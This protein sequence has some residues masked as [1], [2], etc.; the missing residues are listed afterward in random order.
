MVF[1]SGLLANK[2][3]RA[4]IVVIVALGLFGLAWQDRRARI[5]EAK[6]VT[7]KYSLLKVAYA[8]QDTENKNLRTALKRSKTREF[9]TERRL[10]SGEVIITTSRFEETEE[11][12]TA[13]SESTAR[14]VLPSSELLA[15]G[16]VTAPLAFS[17]VATVDGQLNWQAG[18]LWDGLKFDLPLLPAMSIALGATAGPGETR[19]MDWR[20]IAQ[21]HIWHRTRRGP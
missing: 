21:L 4:I 2:K 13:V 11:T 18:L 12:S 14:T 17:P 7:E 5:L 8:N 20:A 3:A 9:T 19:P 6:Q 1:L 10:P 15:T 16:W